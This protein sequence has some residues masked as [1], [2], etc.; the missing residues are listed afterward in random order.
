MQRERRLKESLKGLVP[1]EKKRVF[2]EAVVFGEQAAD[3]FRQEFGI[4]L[5]ALEMAELAEKAGAVVRITQRGVVA[6]FLAEYLPTRSV[7]WD[8]DKRNFETQ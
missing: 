4:P 1:E 5:N 7:G 8:I 2:S 6:G 3:W